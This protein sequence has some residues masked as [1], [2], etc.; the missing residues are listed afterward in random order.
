MIRKCIVGLISFLLVFN[1]TFVYAGWLDDWFDQYTASGPNYYQSQKRGYVT[2]GSLSARTG[3]STPFKLFTFEMPRFRGGCGGIDLFLGSFGFVN[4]EYLVQQLQNLIQAAPIVAFELALNILSSS[5]GNVSDK[6]RAALNLLNQLQ[7][8]ECK[9]LQPILSVDV[10]QLPPGSLSAKAT[11]AVQ[12]IVEGY[13]NL[14]HKAIE[15]V[16]RT[17]SLTEEELRDISKICPAEIWEIANHGS[18]LAYIASYL[19]IPYD[20]ENAIRAITGDFA[21]VSS[22]NGGYTTTWLEPNTTPED[23]RKGVQR[24]KTKDKSG[25]EGEIN[26]GLVERVR[27]NLMEAY[28]AKLSRGSLSP[29][30]EYVKI[31]NFSPFPLETLVNVAAMTKN[32]SLIDSISPT[33]AQG[34]FYNLMLHVLSKGMEIASKVRATTPDTGVC[35]VALNVITGLRD[36]QENARKAASVLAEVYSAS[37]KEN[38]LSFDFALRLLDYYHYVYSK[39]AGAFGGEVANYLIAGMR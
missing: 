36:M 19:G 13:E 34:L 38:S 10:T 12:K 20:L 31:V 17:P 29:S 4:P 9:F 33:V 11:V 23:L 28:N 6:V 24:L 14:W 32:P 3:M 1:I 37:L 16:R 5:L 26:T 25:N 21:I 39:L 30:S 15:E 35:P 2:F 18:A 8:D 27:N 7:F 22:S